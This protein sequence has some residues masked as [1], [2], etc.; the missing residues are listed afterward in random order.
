[1]LEVFLFVNP[2]GTHC[3][4]T[5]AAVT[6]L[7]K[8]IETPIDLHFVMLLNFKI[9]DDLMTSLK[10]DP[11]DLTLRNQLFDAATQVALDYKAAQFQ[12]N[13]KARALLLAEQEMFLDGNFTY[14]AM[15]AAACLRVAGLNPEA[16]AA[17][18]QQL[19]AS[20]C[21]SEDFRL[22]QEFGVTTAPNV[23]VFCPQSGI[24]Q[25]WRLG[26]TPNY[27]RLKAVCGKLT[28][29]SPAAPRLHIL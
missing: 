8:E 10:L 15:F 14:D 2:L 21:F 1:M 29:L 28:T 4:E 3:R 25:G 12:G 11:T 18:R 26:S 17:D 7:A 5:E 27:E 9:I 20:D 22:A 23:V 6:R 19:D 16:F 24:N 13:Q